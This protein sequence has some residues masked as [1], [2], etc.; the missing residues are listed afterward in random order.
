MRSN[1]GAVV[2][3]LAMGLDLSQLQ[4]TFATPSL[5]DGSIVTLTNPQGLVLA[6]SREGDR[7]IGTTVDV[8][9][10]SGAGAPRSPPQTDIDGVERFVASADVGRGPWLL[11]A[12]I[13][14]SLIA[15]RMWPLE[16]RLLAVIAIAAL[17]GQR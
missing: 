11:S 8:P 17:A 13:P 16:W 9:A 3:V 6:R 7:F 10:P 15:A 14:T 1:V 2:G 5:A 12:G 4:S